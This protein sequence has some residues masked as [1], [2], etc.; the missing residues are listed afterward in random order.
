[1]LTEW[2]NLENVGTSG[3]TPRPA[4]PR[5]A[6]PSRLTR[7]FSPPTSGEKSSYEEI[8][9]VSA[10]EG[11][12]WS[13]QVERKR[14]KQATVEKF[15][16]RGKRKIQRNLDFDTSTHKASWPPSWPSCGWCSRR[17]AGSPPLKF[18]NWALNCVSSCCYFEITENDAN[19]NEL[20]NAVQLYLSSFVS[21][22][23]SHLPLTHHQLQRHHLR[24][25]QQQL[26]HGGPP[27][28]VATPSTS[29]WA[30]YRQMRPVTL[31]M[32]PD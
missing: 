9:D 30:F 3:P 27:N 32:D 10:K 8:A 14:I 25:L 23:G 1:M 22:S 26:H 17:T 12:G 4:H 6:L 29:R 20:Y 28:F 15:G 21:A 31:A 18:L 24:P 13:V 19:T 5:H 16:E 11:M 2:K 7:D